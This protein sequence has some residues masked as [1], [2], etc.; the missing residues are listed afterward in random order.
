MRHYQVSPQPGADELVPYR[1]LTD[2]ALFGALGIEL[3]R[4][5]TLVEEYETRADDDRAVR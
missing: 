5:Q 1:C 2:C 4:P 3:A